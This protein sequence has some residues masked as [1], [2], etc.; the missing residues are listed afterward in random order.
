MDSY[1]KLEYLTQ[2]VSKLTDAERR[3]LW[4]C[5]WEE[6]AAELTAEQTSGLVP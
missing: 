5:L 6:Y 2:E 1:E 3:I 4:R